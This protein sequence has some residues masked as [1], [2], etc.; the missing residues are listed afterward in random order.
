MA[1]HRARRKEHRLNKPKG[2]V[3]SCGLM[4]FDSRREADFGARFMPL[5][6]TQV[7]RPYLCKTGCGLWHVGYLPT[8]VV[9]G[10]V[11]ADEWYGRNGHQAMRKVIPPLL[12]HITNVTRFGTPTIARRTCLVTDRDLWTVIIDTPNAGQLIARDYDSP[13][14]AATVALA[15]YHAV[16]AGTPALVPELALVAA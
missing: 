15:E 6:R 5:D 4:A 8:L 2:A 11:T 13:A 3:N 12:E 9:Q 7:A 10:V 1:K 14:E 16:I